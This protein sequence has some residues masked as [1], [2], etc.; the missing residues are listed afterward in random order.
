QSFNGVDVNLGARWGTA[1]REARAA[2]AAVTAQPSG[3]PT[4]WAVGGT[5]GYAGFTI[6]GSYAENDN[7]TAGNVGDQ[8]GWSLGATYDIAGPWSVGLDTYQGEVTTNAAGGKAEY[9][10][11]QLVGRR[12]LGAGVNWDVYAVYA[13]G[14][15]RDGAGNF[16]RIEGTVIGTSINLSF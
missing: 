15:T 9:A 4:V 6:G 16:N 12:A 3:D 13:E 14:K 5:V 11:Y 7:D 10:A 8:E 2:V 1:E